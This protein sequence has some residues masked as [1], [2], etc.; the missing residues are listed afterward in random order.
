MERFA[1]TKTGG[2]VSNLASFDI[3]THNRVLIRQRKANPSDPNCQWLISVQ[4]VEPNAGSTISIADVSPKIQFEK[5][6]KPDDGRKAGRSDIM[7]EKRNDANPSLARK[8][9][10]LQS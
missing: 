7:H 3:S 1:G 5:I 2:P 4:G 6:G 8:G 10:D 9:I